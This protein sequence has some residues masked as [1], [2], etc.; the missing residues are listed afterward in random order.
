MSDY[1]QFF[2][3]RPVSIQRINVTI[4]AG[5]ASVTAAISAVDM[6]K[7]VVTMSPSPSSTSYPNEELAVRLNS[8]T[9]ITVERESG[10]SAPTLTVTV[11]VVDFGPMVKNV[12]RGT[13]GPS[14]AT[15]AAIST[16]DPAKCWVLISRRVDY[17]TQTNGGYTLS[18]NA[19]TVTAQNTTTRFWQIVEFW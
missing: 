14:P 17:A 3:D 1:M 6:G 12:Q 4:P 7:S 9:Q 18:A 5:A 8:A 11:T 13:I 10:V 19:L 16:V 2:G 15:T